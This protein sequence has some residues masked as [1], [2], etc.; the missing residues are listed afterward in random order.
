MIKREAVLTLATPLHHGTDKSRVKPG[1][2]PAGVK[3][4]YT[5]HRRLP[6]LLKFDSGRE[7]IE[8]VPVVSGN[9]IR[10]QWRESLV[11]V[12]LYILGLTRKDLPKN[13][14]ETFVSGGGMD[15]ADAIKND[16][17]EEKVEITKSKKKILQPSVPILVRDRETLRATNPLLSLF[18]CSYGNRMLPGLV[19]VG[20]AIPVLKE[21]Q[22]ITKV[23]SNLN[24]SADLTSFQ[25]A[26]RHDPLR[27][28]MDDEYKSRQSIYSLEV[29]GAGVPFAHSFSIDLATPVE[30]AAMQLAINL[31]K[32]N[33]YLGGKASTG[34]GQFTTDNF[35]EDLNESPALYIQFLKDNRDVLVEYI[36]LWNKPEK[37]VNVVNKK[38]VL[39]FPKDLSI[40]LDRLVRERE[41]AIQIELGKS[42]QHITGLVN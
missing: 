20:W 21:T 5:P 9:S 12:T 19:K 35:Y 28:D 26:T 6:L 22:H 27:N 29:V 11:D 37:I 30:R 4:N 38:E 15:S 17:E 41:D 10:H 18:G 39:E 14:L 2:L 8:Q 23:D 42:F 33:P 7:V 13:I 1:N 31:F 3:N 36:K 32:E 34:H 25:M 40:E 16:E 24:F